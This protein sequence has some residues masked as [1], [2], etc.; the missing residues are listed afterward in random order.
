MPLKTN[1]SQ[2]CPIELVIFVKSEEQGEMTEA[3]WSFPNTLELL[4]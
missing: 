1:I 3:A 2:E 4:A